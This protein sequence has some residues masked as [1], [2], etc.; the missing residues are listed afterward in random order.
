MLVELRNSHNLWMAFVWHGA[1]LSTMKTLLI[2]VV[3]CV[4]C[5]IEEAIHI[6]IR[7]APYIGAVIVAVGCVVGALMGRI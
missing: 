6:L 7:A 2:F 1:E 4:G 3:L 5:V